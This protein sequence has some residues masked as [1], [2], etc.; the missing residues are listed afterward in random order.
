MHFRV[1]RVTYTDVKTTYPKVTKTAYPIICQIV[2]VMP[3]H[4]IAQ[5]AMAKR[6]VF[7]LAFDFAPAG[8]GQQT[9]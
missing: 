1:V 6:L 5:A 7:Q 2:N 4:F 3:N 9:C 8:M